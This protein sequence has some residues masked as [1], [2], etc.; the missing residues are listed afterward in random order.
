MVSLSVL[1]GCSSKAVYD[2]VQL[3]NRTDCNRVPPPQYEEC[4]ERTDK[5][6]EEYER[7]RK[8]LIGGE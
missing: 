3:N 4:I 6:Y 2:N 7:E 8:E 1:A 5:S